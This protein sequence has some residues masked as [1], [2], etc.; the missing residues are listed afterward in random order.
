M[1]QTLSREIL[2][3]FLMLLENKDT[4][5]RRKL[6]Y[7]TWYHYR[8]TK[9]TDSFTGQSYMSL[10]QNDSLYESR[11]V[12]S[13]YNDDALWKVD[14]GSMGV[15]GQINNLK[16]YSGNMAVTDDVISRLSLEAAHIQLFGYEKDS[17]VLRYDM[18][19]TV[20]ISLKS[21]VDSERVRFNR[22]FTNTRDPDGTYH[23]INIIP[24]R[25]NITIG[26]VS[27]VNKFDA[28]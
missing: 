1:S 10:V 3:R 12:S 26:G 4:D 17:E 21:G 16:I 6:Q 27:V 8:I 13:S 11:L 22:I 23:I 9:S 7:G 2:Y 25:E 18:D 19:D 24:C 15:S 14:I 20:P 5:S 28:I